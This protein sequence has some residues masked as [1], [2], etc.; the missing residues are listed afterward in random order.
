MDDN[1]NKM[2]EFEEFTKAIRDYRIEVPEA[3]L[4]KLYQAFDVD[5]NGSI[6]Y[7]EFLRIIRGDMNDARKHLVAQAF[8]KIDKTGDGILQ[9]ED[10]KDVY[11]ARHHPDVRSG[12]KTEEEILGEFLSTFETH[13]S[14]KMGGVGLDQRVTL[15][16]FT[17][18]YTNISACIDDDRYFELMMTNAWNF[19]NVS[20]AKGWSADQTSSPAKRRIF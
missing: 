15:E 10:I 17:E 13:H 6:V 20:H 1:D 9:M 16:E 8:K 5:G 4:R 18:Y 11:N 14:V 12:K 3:D 2:L 7:D 19:A